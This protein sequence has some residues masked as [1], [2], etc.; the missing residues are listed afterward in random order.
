MRLVL[1][2]IFLLIVLAVAAVFHVNN[3]QWVT[4]GFYLGSVRSPLSLVVAVAL[5]AGACLGGTMNVWVLNSQRRK[6]AKL[7]RALKKIERQTDAP[8]VAMKDAG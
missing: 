2:L 4:V 1:T 3:S 7:K 8:A 6:I 5:L